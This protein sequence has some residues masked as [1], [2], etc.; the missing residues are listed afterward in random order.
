MNDPDNKTVQLHLIE[1]KII[2]ARENSYIKRG[3]LLWPLCYTNSF[4]HLVR[5]KGLLLSTEATV[6]APVIT[7]GPGGISLI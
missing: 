3:R 5:V 6:I 4:L 2:L 7:S 1:L